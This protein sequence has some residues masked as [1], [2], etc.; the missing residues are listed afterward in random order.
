MQSG[1]AV[2][3]TTWLQSVKYYLALYTKKFV[4]SCSAVLFCGN[5]KGN[6]LYNKLDGTS[7]LCVVVRIDCNSLNK[8]LSTSW[9]GHWGKRN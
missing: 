6:F 1:A 4:S 5:Y 2:T 7:Q 9:L 3:E 8:H